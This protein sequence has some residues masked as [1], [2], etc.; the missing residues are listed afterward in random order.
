[1]DYQLKLSAPWEDVKERIKETN[2]N[3]IDEDLQY[4][5]GQEE[6]LIK[7]LSVKLGK[8]EQHTKDWLESVAFTKDIAS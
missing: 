3:I 2:I 6:A 5:P 4:K 1:M 7:K 8:D